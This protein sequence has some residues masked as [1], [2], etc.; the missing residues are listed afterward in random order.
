MRAPSRASRKR[1]RADDL[2]RLAVQCAWARDDWHRCR[3]VLETRYELDVREDSNLCIL[4]ARQH[5]RIWDGDEHERSVARECRGRDPG[6]SPH[7]RLRGM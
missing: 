4:S 1:P 2:P 3:S 6:L 7:R 5:S